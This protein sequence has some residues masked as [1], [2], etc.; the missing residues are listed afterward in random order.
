MTRNRA[1]ELTSKPSSPATSVLI[2]K[3]IKNEGQVTQSCKLTPWEGEIDGIINDLVVHITS[4]PWIN[5]PIRPPG[6]ATF[7]ELSPFK[8]L[9]QRT[10]M[11]RTM[12]L[13]RRLQKLLLRCDVL[14]VDSSSTKD[15]HRIIALGVLENW[16]VSVLRVRK[17]EIITAQVLSRQPLL[18][19]IHF[20]IEFTYCSLKYS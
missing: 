8:V 2:Y 11:K 10:L 12:S 19:H 7:A 5:S 9:C 20:S 13:V 14:F 16:E 3:M 6:E 18:V 17:V 1:E 15:W 4:I